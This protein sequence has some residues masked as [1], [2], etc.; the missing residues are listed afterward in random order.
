M[1]STALEQLHRARAQIQRMRAEGSEFEQQAL[2][3]L[4]SGLGGVTG[5]LVH[6]FLPVVIPGKAADGPVL[7]VTAILFDALAAWSGSH[8]VLAMSYAYEG[9]LSGKA[10]DHAMGWAPPLNQSFTSP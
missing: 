10:L 2:G 6:R 5:A 7:G 9:Y 8:A 1:A 3:H 4:M